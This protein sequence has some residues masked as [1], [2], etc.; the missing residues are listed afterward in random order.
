MTEVTD[1]CFG[2][3]DMRLL[4]DGLEY[5]KAFAMRDADGNLPDDERSKAARETIIEPY[6]RLVADEFGLS[7]DDVWTRQEELVGLG[8]ASDYTPRFELS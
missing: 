7:Y 3:L 6:T 4:D 1:R 5:F 2:D 8:F